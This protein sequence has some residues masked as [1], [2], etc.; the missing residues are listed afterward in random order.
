MSLLVRSEIV[1]NICKF[2]LKDP[3]TL[4]CS[5]DICGKH[6]RDGTVKNGVITC[7]KCKK[8][9]DVP[10]KGFAPN[11]E[12]A[13]L[14]ANEFHLSNEEKTTKQVIQD[15][16]NQLE[17]LQ[18]LVITSKRP[19]MQL[20]TFEHFTEIRR[21]IDIHREELKN[22]I[23]SIAL[24]LIDQTK[25]W[26]HAYKTKRNKIISGVVDTDL[27]KY[28]HQLDHEFRRSNLLI[29]DAERIKNEHVH[30]MAEFKTKMNKFASL[31][32][33]IKSLEFMPR[34]EHQ[35]IGFG[36]LRLKGSP[37]ACVLN[38]KIQICN[39]ASNECVANLEGHFAK[40]QFLENID[41]FRFASG[42]LD[43]TIRIWD[44][45]NFAC[46]KTLATGHKYGVYCIRSLTSNLIASGSYEEIK[47]WNLESAECLQT[48]NAHSGYIYDLG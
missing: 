32:K 40:I 48:L 9:F 1:C 39:L 10:R 18:H 35:E 29:K 25:K 19:E 44:A 3:V 6:L 4:P 21:Q 8:N 28:T 34:L 17:E 12:L 15:L 33:E 7:E 23:D 47:I 37:I 41:D 46:L 2:I 13:N 11:F 27:E 26:E 38:N 22:K 20:T 5:S 14:L 45:K 24:K 36:S 31:G 16:I 43:N 42:S 30:R